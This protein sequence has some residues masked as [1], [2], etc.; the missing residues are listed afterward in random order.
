MND[1]QKTD[2]TLRDVDAETVTQFIKDYPHL[3]PDRWGPLEWHGSAEVAYNEENPRMDRIRMNAP[4]GLDA[5]KGT[6]CVNAN[7]VYCAPR[8]LREAATAFLDMA[9]KLEANAGVEA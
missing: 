4:P 2:L 9:D 1:Q 8:H 7:N 6:V 3:F 5:L